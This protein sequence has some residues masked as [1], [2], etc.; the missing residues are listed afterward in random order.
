MS[1]TKKSIL[2][3]LLI[4]IIDQVLKIWVK[5][6]MSLY[7]QIPLIGHKFVLHFIENNGMAFGLRLPGNYGKLI[8]T[9]FRLAAAIT[10][11]FYLR[12][13]IRSRAPFGLVACLSMIMAG[14]LGNIIDSAFYGMIFSG[15]SSAT[16][17]T[18]FPEGGG[19]SSFLHG[20]VVDMFYAPVING[21]YPSWFPFR[22]GEAFL[23]FR[24]VFNVA[25]A[26]ITIAVFII[27]L[28]Q[29]KFFHTLTEKAEEIEANESESSE[30]PEENM[31]EERP[32]V[33]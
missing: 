20:K 30:N 15:S 23:F 19:Y 3:V 9:L 32:S 24:P 6:H 13:L 31:K 11:V 4:L 5:T 28:N 17:A 27:L 2:I 33:L 14:A 21:T 25:D 1:D 8:L 7:E 22:A 16:V 12:Y 18:L 10:I 29:K 26:S